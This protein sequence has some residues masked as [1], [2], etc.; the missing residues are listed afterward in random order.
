MALLGGLGVSE[1][2]GHPGIF[3]GLGVIAV[4]SSKSSQRFWE[5]FFPPYLTLTFVS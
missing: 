5:C 2:A 1:G 3:K 4:S